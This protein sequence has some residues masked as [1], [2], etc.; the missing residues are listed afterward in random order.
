MVASDARSGRQHGGNEFLRRIEHM[1]VRLPRLDLTLGDV[2]RI[3]GEEV[4]A[5]RRARRNRLGLCGVIEP[6]RSGLAAMAGVL[7]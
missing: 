4:K 3:V 1:R 2:N 6:P 7:R 5:V